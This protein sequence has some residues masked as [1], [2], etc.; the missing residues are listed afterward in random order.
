MKA[1]LHLVTDGEE[2]RGDKPESV[3]ELFEA[4]VNEGRLDRIVRLYDTGAILVE[5][6]GS[7]VAGAAAIGEYFRRLLSLKPVIRLRTVDTIDTGEVAVLVSD[8][9]LKGTKPD[10]SE[11]AGNGRTYDIVRRTPDGTWRVAVDNPW[12]AVLPDRGKGEA[13][14]EEKRHLRR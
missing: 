12:G 3:H 4:G 8:W 2:R 6:D 7:V 5:K 9:T 11:V 1:K 14:P 10:G 13:R